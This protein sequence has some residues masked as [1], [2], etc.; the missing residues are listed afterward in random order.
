MRDMHSDTWEVSLSIQNS[1]FDL[2]NSSVNVRHL[3]SSNV[4][5]M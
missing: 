5:T 2:E 1:T 4:T 3:L